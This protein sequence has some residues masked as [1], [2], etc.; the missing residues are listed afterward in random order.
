M[1]LILKVLKFLFPGLFIDNNEETTPE[2]IYEQKNFMTNAEK[3]FYKKIVVLEENYKIIPQINLAT[4]VKKKS[5]YKYRTELY[6]N[7]DF[8]IFDKDLNNV[9]LLIELNDSTHN[10]KSRIDRDLKVKK[11]CTDANLKLINFYTKYPNEQ[12]YV[13]K[14]IKTEIAQTKKED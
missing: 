3:D 9:L 11:I 4:I 8:A 6:R 12:E 10:Q 13:I 5:K 1:K 14:R 7:I 2:I